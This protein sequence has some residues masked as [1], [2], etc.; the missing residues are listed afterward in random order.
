MQSP[1]HLCHGTKSQYFKELTNVKFFY[2]SRALNKRYAILII[3]ILRL[4][5]EG[6]IVNFYYLWSQ[7]IS[8]RDGVDI[9]MSP[10]G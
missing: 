10:F 6:F 8:L 3:S 2:L 7:T 1:R 9:Q 4:Y 5:L